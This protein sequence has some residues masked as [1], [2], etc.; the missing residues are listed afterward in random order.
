MPIQ[1]YVTYLPKK[2]SI[3]LLFFFLYQVENEIYAQLKRNA[4]NKKIKKE[5]VHE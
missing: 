2:K 5:E 3:T 4:E 1:D